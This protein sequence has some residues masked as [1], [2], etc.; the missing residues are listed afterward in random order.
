MKDVGLA[1]RM[2]LPKME[3]CLVCH[4]NT[5]ASADCRTCHV[6]APSG[7]LT[8]AF[9]AGVLRPMQGNP[10]GMDHGPRY[11]FNHGTRAKLDR[12][13]C[14]QCHAESE[15][16]QCHDSLQKPLAVHPNDY[17]RIHP[18]EA[19][20][21]T[22]KCDSCHRYQS[23]CAACHER[24]GVGLS[25]A[26]FFRARNVRVHPDYTTWVI[27]LG[28]QHHGIQASRNIQECISCHRQ[29]DCLP[30]HA[31]NPGLGIPTRYSENGHPGVDPHPNG[32]AGICKGLYSR[33]KRP[34]LLCHAATSADI[35]Q[36]M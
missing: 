7:R 33:N 3:T 17:I 12:G 18:I 34:C 30:C 36:C 14:M 31:N 25:A 2:Q 4:D 16:L 13:T 8:L 10:Y 24:A 28:P 35:A 1:T 11:E 29:E 9:T 26:A 32:F 22:P 6:T 15:C 21:D 27:T 5:Y 20:M 23:F 19:R